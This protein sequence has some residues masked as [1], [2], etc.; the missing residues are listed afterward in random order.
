MIP[1]WAPTLFVVGGQPFAL[2]Y[3]LEG[4]PALLLLK[5]GEARF[6]KELWGGA[7]ADRL[8]RAPWPKPMSL[9]QGFEEHGLPGHPPPLCL[10]AGSTEAGSN[11]SVAAEMKA[12]CEWAAEWALHMANQ[13]ELRATGTQTGCLG[14]PALH[15][16]PADLL[17]P[18]IS[19][20]FA[21]PRALS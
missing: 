15:L 16:P 7:W 3:R 21:W 1:P 12:S 17:H 8:L 9:G 20:W 19:L 2:L 5:W 10:P 11:A 6:L 13:P 4:K 18:R 14:L